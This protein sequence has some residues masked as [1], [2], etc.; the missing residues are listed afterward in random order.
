MNGIAASRP[1]AAAPWPTILLVVGA[2]V[3]SAF[4]VGKAP[5]ALDAIRT[6]LGLDL[7]T[8][9]WLLS[10]FAVIGALAGIGIGVAVDHI[11]ARRVALGGL[12]LQAACGALG[13][14]ADG[15]PLLLAT[16]VVEGLGFLAVG[17]AAPALIV[18]VAPPSAQARAFA[19]WSTFMP[20]GIAMVMLGVPLLSASG[21]RGFWLVN[22][23][24]LAGYAGLLAAG[25]RGIPVHI[26]A[27]RNIANDVR[28]TLAAP[29]PWMLAGLFAAFA[30]SFFAVFGFL[31]SIL[32]GRLGAGLETATFLTAAAVA[33]NAAGNIAGG[34]LLARGVRRAHI[35]LIGFGTIALSGFG[36]LAEGTPGWLAFALCVAFSAVSGIVPVAIIDGAARHAPRPDLVGT[37]VGFIM[38]G[39][40]VG[41][42][43]GPAAAGALAVRFGWPSVSFFVA[44]AAV[45]AGLL[46]V[47][48]QARP[49]EHARRA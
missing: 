21:W 41:L 12:L 27:R 44:A 25:T 49:A 29:G 11:G 22:A 32:S 28:D 2:G 47:F 38:Q 30:T 46:A 43:L 31:P 13:T 10:A 42:M 18:S 37:T 8:A 19:V 45:A 36:I 23:V 40:N 5:M 26:S 14:L 35:L 20:V 4:Q 15:A 34:V 39:N 24:I 3:V 48:L 16:R 17:V 9:S 7:A 6:D 1:A 33:S